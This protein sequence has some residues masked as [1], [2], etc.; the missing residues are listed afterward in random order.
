MIPPIPT[1]PSG[2]GLAATSQGGPESLSS[3]CS[4]VIQKVPRKITFM[5][6]RSIAVKAEKR[7]VWAKRE[8]RAVHIGN[9]SV[10]RPYYVGNS[11]DWNEQEGSVDIPLGRKV[12]VFGEL[13]LFGGRG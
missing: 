10:I 12:E 1:L 3:V 2:V 8:N 9:T 6:H 4:R 11:K 13:R 7:I 5:V